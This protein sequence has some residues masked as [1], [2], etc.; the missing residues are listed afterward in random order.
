MVVGV[1]RCLGRDAT[2]LPGRVLTMTVHSNDVQ[3]LFLQAVF[4]R[5]ILSVKHAQ[6]LWEKCIDAVKG[7]TQNLDELS[8]VTEHPS[9]KL[10]IPLSPYGSTTAD[11]HGT[12]LLPI[13]TLPSIPL[14]LNFVIWRTS[15]PG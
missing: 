10:P 1:L 11:K 14:T 4:S 12:D 8:N 3:R 7:L 5:G 6:V 13:L 2:S 9:P 15:R